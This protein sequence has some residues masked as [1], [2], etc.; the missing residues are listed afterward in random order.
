VEVRPPDPPLADGVVA[1]R[2]W[3][4]ADAAAIAAACVEEEIVRWM[5]QIPQPYTEADAR[6]FLAG[7]AAQ[8]RDGTGG[9][10][11]I[12]EAASGELAGSIAMRV[13]DPEQA[14]V[15]VGYWAAAPARGRG[16][17]T[18]ALKLLSG[19]LL[20]S[21]GAERVQLRADVLNLASQ[22]VAEKAGY[23]REGVLRSS[24]VHPHQGRRIDYAIF[25]L[26]PGELA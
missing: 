2:P 19:W 15:E 22:R 3:T 7:A 10:F 11:A 23:V 9:T 13:T 8:W 5:H 6:E 4:E 1:L 20:E 17:T 16:L 21:V 26:L 14:I 12:V 24:G 25:S 18:R